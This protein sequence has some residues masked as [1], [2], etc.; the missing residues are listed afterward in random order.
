[1]YLC[2]HLSFRS[3][4]HIWRKI[5]DSCVSDDLQFHLFTCEQ[6]NFILLYGWIILHCVYKTH[7]LNL[8]IACSASGLF[9]KLA[10]V[11]SATI[12][13]GVQVALLHLG[14]HSF[15]HMPRSGIAGSYGRCFFGFLSHLL[16]LSIHSTAHIPRVRH[17]PTYSHNYYHTQNVSQWFTVP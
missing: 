13:M 6:Y 11:N 17:S 9:P 12:N 10:V 3:S 16:L 2:V 5:C 7:F 15:R 4:F 1:M 14:A 8:F